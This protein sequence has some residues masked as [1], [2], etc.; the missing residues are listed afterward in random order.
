M[1]KLPVG[2]VMAQIKQLQGRIIEKILKEEKCLE[3][4]N[5]AQLNILYQLW[6]QDNITISELSKE[7]L[8][9]NTTL[10]TM[11]DRLEAQGLILRCRNTENRREI[12]IKLTDTSK[13]MKLHTADILK[14]MHSINFNDFTPE[15]EEQMY[16]YLE[17]MKKNLEAYS[18]HHK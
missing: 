15:E 10:T 6:N 1:S 14:T 7:T 16:I 8:L 3:K 4:V 5:G 13:S 18:Y 9:A 2:I 11:L 12:R 17:R